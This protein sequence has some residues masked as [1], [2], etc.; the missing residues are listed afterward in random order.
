MED[1]KADILYKIYP[2]CSK[3]RE[4][5]K[6]CVLKNGSAIAFSL[7][8]H[9]GWIRKKCKACLQNLFLCKPGLQDNVITSG[10]KTSLLRRKKRFYLQRVL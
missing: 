10:D 7:F 3:C 4:V 1:Y 2:L 8:L 9:H 5:C 6:K